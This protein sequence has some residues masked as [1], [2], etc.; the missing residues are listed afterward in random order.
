[1]ARSLARSCKQG[2]PEEN[3]VRTSTTQKPLWHRCPGT[4]QRQSTFEQ[5]TA[6]QGTLCRCE[7]VDIFTTVINIY[8]NQRPWHKNHQY[9]TFSLT[10]GHIRHTAYNEQLQP[11]KESITGQEREGGI[12]DNSKGHTQSHHCSGRRTSSST[13]LLKFTQL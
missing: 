10:E 8:E 4:K 5:G 12:E 1:M 3:N 9:F 7:K 11:S 2:R 13:I 6:I